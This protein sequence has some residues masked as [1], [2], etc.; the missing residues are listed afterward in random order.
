M[1][2]DKGVA[3]DDSDKDLYGATG[4]MDAFRGSPEA[5]RE[6]V[7][8]VSFPLL[9]PPAVWHRPKDGEEV[10]ISQ[11]AA[12]MVYLGDKLGYAPSSDAERARAN[13]VLMNAMDY[14]AEGRRTFHPVKDKMSYKD[15]KEEGD[16]ASKEFSQSRMK[17]FLYHFDKTVAVKGP[18]SPIAGGSNVTYADFAL[19]HVLDATVAQFNSN[20]YD[21]AWDKL[22]VP[23]LKEYYNWMK[24]RPNLQAYFQSDRCARKSPCIHIWMMNI[25]HCH[26]S[27]V[28]VS[29]SFC[30]R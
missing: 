20:F 8:G 10:M 19:F 16:K 25:W 24:A 12:C 6:E 17:M 18:K 28:S 22:D 13:S 5:A 30:G 15:Q 21:H 4:M 1:L 23:L 11:S 27:L 9:F 2:E 26:L 3:Y 14:I 29:S 7:A